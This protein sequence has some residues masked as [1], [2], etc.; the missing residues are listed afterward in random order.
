VEA[1]M[2]LLNTNRSC[3]SA[4]MIWKQTKPATGF[5]KLNT[6]YVLEV[7]A[8]MRGSSLCCSCREH[9]PQ[10]VQPVAALL[11]KTQLE[12]RLDKR[13]ICGDICCVSTFEQYDR[14]QLPGVTA[15]V[16]CS[17]PITITAA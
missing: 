5:M 9:N 8:V 10:G 4:G 14:A 16:T 1:N 7:V 17:E 15:G 13:S 3:F 2:Q 12:T 6:V 11:K